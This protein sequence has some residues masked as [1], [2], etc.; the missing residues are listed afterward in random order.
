[1]KTFPSTFPPPENKTSEKLS[2]KH[3]VTDFVGNKRIRR[4]TRIRTSEIK[5]SYVLTK[6]QVT[7]FKAFWRSIGTDDFILNL[8]M[9]YK[10]RDF[11]VAFMGN[12]EI[13]P[14]TFT[15][16]RV[17]FVLISRQPIRISALEFDVEKLGPFVVSDWTLIDRLYAITD[18]ELPRIFNGYK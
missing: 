18:I 14:I 8:S 15:Y 4:K 5:L 13:E 10:P 7:D 11:T 9:N 17:S 16:S 12:I 1:M 6:D 3:S 2:S